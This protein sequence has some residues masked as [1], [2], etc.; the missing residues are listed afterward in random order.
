M[1]ADAISDIEENYGRFKRDRIAV[2]VLGIDDVAVHFGLE[3]DEEKAKELN[4]MTM[5]ELIDE[6][7]KL[8]KEADALKDA[9]IE[10]YKDVQAREKEAEEKLAQALQKLQP[11]TA[12]NGNGA[13]EASGGTT[14]GGT[15]G[16]TT[17]GGTGG[18]SGGTTGG[19]TG[20]TSGGTTGGTGGTS[21]GT[22][23]G[24]SGTG[25]AIVQNTITPSTGTGGSLQT[26]PA[27]NTG[28]GSSDVATNAA[29][30]AA[31][32]TADAAAATGDTAVPA[33]GEGT[34]AAA[35]AAVADAGDAGG[36]DL[37]AADDVPAVLGARS[38]R[39]G[40]TAQGA[41]SDV[42]GQAVLGATRSPLD[43]Q[44]LQNGNMQDGTVVFADIP[45]EGV[46]LSNGSDLN[47]TK[48]D[49]TATPNNPTVNIKDDG[50]ALANNIQT[51]EDAQKVSWWWLLI[52]FLLGA[53]G[54]KSYD[55]HMRRKEENE[56]KE[57]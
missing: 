18:T 44:T 28:T 49:K 54:K 50:V 35:S 15:S 16:G 5:T 38:D 19:S 30:A 29:N 36:T 7:N 10:S 57:S 41:R 25:G 55:E 43:G 17:G 1:F 53:T 20:G 8:K 12:Q 22:A 27:S 48:G 13:G 2:N 33:T 45:D 9:A 56:K 32:Q 46:A 3:V 47:K 14:G 6:L 52:I 26:T 21:G 51:A 23:G 11:D 34:P 42:N 40:T 37:A 31:S 4:G 39:N 24:G